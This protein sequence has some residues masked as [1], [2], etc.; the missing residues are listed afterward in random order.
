MFLSKLL[1]HQKY[2][3]A[4]KS[5]QDSGKEILIA[6]TNG[7]YYAIGNVCTHMGGDLQKEH[8]K[9]TSLPAPSIEQNL[10]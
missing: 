3:R 7:V 8:L 6:N 4:N 10:M 5:L 1:K 2:H 9:E